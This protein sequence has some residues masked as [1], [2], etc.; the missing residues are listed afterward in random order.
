M[1]NIINGD[2]QPLLFTI[3]INQIHNVV[4]GSR[5]GWEPI[6]V[7]YGS[8]GWRIRLPEVVV[9]QM[10]PAQLLSVNKGTKNTK[11]APKNTKTAPI[12]R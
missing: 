8:N 5:D 1:V 10:M 2:S 7:D 4:Q 11:T 9:T 3:L 6:D 12:S